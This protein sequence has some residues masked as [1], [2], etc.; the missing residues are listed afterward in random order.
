MN[1]LYFWDIEGSGGSNFIKMTL[2]NYSIPQ[3][4]YYDEYGNIQ[5]APDRITKTFKTIDDITELE[6]SDFQPK[7]FSEF[8]PKKIPRRKILIS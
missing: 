5:S 1:A 8:T 4:D 3:D 6:F 7:I 2:S